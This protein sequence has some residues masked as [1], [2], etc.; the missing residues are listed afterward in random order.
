MLLI[1]ALSSVVVK[2]LC[3]NPVRDKVIKWYKLTKPSG[4]TRL[5]ALLSLKHK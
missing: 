2:A 1:G 5:W 4:R 3:Y